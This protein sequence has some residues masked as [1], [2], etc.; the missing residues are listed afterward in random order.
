MKVVVERF[1][2]NNLFQD[3]KFM[4][5]VAKTVMDVWW[6][7]WRK[8]SIYKKESFPAIYSTFLFLKK[9]IML[10]AR[11]MK[12]IE[13]LRNITEDGKNNDRI[14]WKIKKNHF[15]SSH[16]YIFLSAIH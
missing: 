1:G 4:K 3:I 7:S 14:F 10:L 9:I 2:Y 15:L 11:G 6:N 5:S 16:I 13:F 8:Q 12:F